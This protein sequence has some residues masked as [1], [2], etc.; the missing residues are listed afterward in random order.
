MIDEEDGREDLTPVATPSD[1]IRLAADKYLGRC[2]YACVAVSYAEDATN[3]TPPP[4]GAGPVR[5][6][7]EAAVGN[8]VAFWDEL[9]FLTPS[10]QQAIRYTAL[11]L[12]ADVLEEEENELP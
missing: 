3:V 8:Q 4:Y 9:L 6:L 2:L 7:V 10:E 12:L 1:V 5:K 11:R